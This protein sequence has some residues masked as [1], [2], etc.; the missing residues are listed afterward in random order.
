MT[1][2][3]FGASHKEVTMRQVVC[4]AAFL[5]FALYVP[6]A[7]ALDPTNCGTPDEPKAC[8]S[9][10]GSSSAPAHST[11]KT[12]ATKKRVVHRPT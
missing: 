10:S 12:H 1:N 11:H 6:S 9:S 4:L 7:H 2:D 3:R 8:G 5:A